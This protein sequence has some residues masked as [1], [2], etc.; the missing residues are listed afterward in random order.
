MN[1]VTGEKLGPTSRAVQFNWFRVT[2]SCSLVL[3]LYPLVSLAQLPTVSA[4]PSLAAGSD[5]KVSARELRIPE[6]AR[7]A[8][9]KGTKLIAA[10]KSAASIPEFER[11]IKVFPGFYEA[12]YKIGLANLNLQRYADAQVAFE[13]SI[14]LSSGRYP[15]AQ[16]G[17]G[18]VLCMQERFADAE[19]AVRAG[20]EAYPDD[21]A[22]QFMLAW[23]LFRADRLPE[24]EKSAQ[25]AV[26]SNPNL[27]GAYLL[28][29]QIHS[30]R[31]DLLSLVSDLDAYLR[32]EPAGPRS[33]QAKVLREQAEQLLAKQRGNAPVVAKTPAP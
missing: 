20:L 30:H 8:F 2:S 7:T 11:A 31:N 5:S 9:N 16:F 33:A 22:G 21:A 19:E 28:L 12:Y 10:N 4:P 13:K 24:S 6:K 14:E 1:I 3:L 23:V 26:L 25:Q 15:P 18:A 17:L 32:L 29:A 27:T